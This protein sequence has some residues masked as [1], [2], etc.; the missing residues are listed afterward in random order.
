MYANFDAVLVH[1][2]ALLTV[3]TAQNVTITGFNVFF[4]SI[5]LQSV[6]TL[7]LSS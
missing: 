2:P 5:L 1:P 4:I 7:R 3:M 6:N